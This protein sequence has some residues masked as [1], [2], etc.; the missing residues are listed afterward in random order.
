M[1]SNLRLYFL[2][3]ALLAAT[4]AHAESAS[5]GINSSQENTTRPVESGQTVERPH[6]E[7]VPYGLGEKASTPATA[8]RQRTVTMIAPDP[9][10]PSVQQIWTSP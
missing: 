7:T 3:S 2:S 1:K 5:D 6:T 8:D 10:S 9:S 4:A